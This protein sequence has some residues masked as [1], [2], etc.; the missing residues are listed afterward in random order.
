MSY[1]TPH[2]AHEFMKAASLAVVHEMVLA[3]QRRP[4]EW[5]LE[6]L[7]GKKE[8]DFNA[9]LGLFFGVESYISAQGSDGKDLIIES[10]TMRVELKYLRPKP[11]S[12]SP[13]NTWDDVIGKDWHWLMGLKNAGEAFK[14]SAFIAF[15][16]G[17]TNFRFHLCFQ[18]P[19][20]Q[21]HQQLHERDY[22]PFV[23]LVTPNAT[24]PRELE[25]TPHAGWERDVLL[26]KR[27]SKLRVRRQI[28]GHPEDPV[29]C[30][31][32][33]RVGDVGGTPLENLPEYDY[34]GYI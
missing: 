34:A 20:K 28:V 4:Q 29:W 32:F 9:R 2:H 10:P 30:L 13:Q 11:T 24:A 14:K 21:F 6:F 31:I 33:S 8:I 1:T 12:N 26:W 3:C 7:R 27:G 15:L 16:P 18:V 17:T 25:Y 5:K 22:A 19:K 23:K